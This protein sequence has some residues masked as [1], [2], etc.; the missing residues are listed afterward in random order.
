MLRAAFRFHSI[1]QGQLCDAIFDHT[2][3][4]IRIIFEDKIFRG[5]VRFWRNDAQAAL[6]TSSVIQR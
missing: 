6:T 2:R 1:A 3:V 4:R 5:G